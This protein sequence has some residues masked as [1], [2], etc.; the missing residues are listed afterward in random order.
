VVVLPDEMTAPPMNPPLTF[1]QDDAQ[2]SPASWK[3][4]FAI[5]RFPCTYMLPLMFD[6]VLTVMFPF[7]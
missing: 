6:W 3:F 7:E 5:V 2:A 4:P 1:T